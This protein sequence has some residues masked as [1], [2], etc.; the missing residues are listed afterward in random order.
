MSN[1]VK[2]EVQQNFNEVDVYDYNLELV[3]DVDMVVFDVRVEGYYDDEN[4]K[5]EGK[6][7]E[8]KKWLIPNEMYLS[9]VMS[10]MFTNIIW[11]LI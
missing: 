4:D 9:T 10:F 5:V 6:E 3:Q 7:E 11:I 8:D 1:K 2:I